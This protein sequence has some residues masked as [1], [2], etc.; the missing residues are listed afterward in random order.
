MDENKAKK[1]SRP[2]TSGTSSSRKLDTSPKSTKSK[3][4]SP[5]KKGSASTSKSI[6]LKSSMSNK[7]NKSNKSSKIKF[8]D[9]SEH[10]NIEELKSTDELE[11]L[12]MQSLTIINER[13]FQ[14]NFA[15]FKQFSSTVRLK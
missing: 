3:S 1:S 15:Q 12:S 6:K 4:R 11:D 7:S 8:N 2:K 10:V 14:S 9:Q 5:D 13:I